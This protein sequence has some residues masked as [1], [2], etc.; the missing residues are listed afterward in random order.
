MAQVS[1]KIMGVLNTLEP[2]G[3]PESKLTKVVERELIR[4]L[5][6]YQY[7]DRH[8]QKKYG[9]NFDQFRDAR[10]VEQKG[11]SFEVESDFWEWELAQ[12]G[13]QTM[14]MELNELRCSA[15]DDQ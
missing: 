4:R 3:G 12:D 15:D 11:Y 10:V 6:H 1:E 2:E 5:N 7:L 9:M 13:I 14:A 8:M